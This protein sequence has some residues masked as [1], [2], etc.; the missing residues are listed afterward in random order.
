[1]KVATGLVAV[2]ALLLA[3]C[4]TDGVS[5]ASGT[6]RLRFGGCPHE[7]MTAADAMVPEERL[8]QLTFS[9]ATL[10]VPLDHT[11]LDGESIPIAVVRVRHRQQSRRIGSLVMN[12]GGPGESGLDAISYWASWLSDDVLRRFDVVTFDPRGTGASDPVTCGSIAADHEPTLF[13]DLL[14]PAGY[15]AASDIARQQTDACLR[16]LGGRAPFFNTQETARDMDLLRQALGDRKLS[17]VGFSY[18]AKLGGEYAR[19]FPRTVRALVLDGPS[20]PVTDPI[21][22][23]EAQV[24]GFEHAFGQWVTDCPARPSCQPLG[25]P[26]AYVATLVARANAAPINSARPGDDLPATGSDVLL[27]VEAFLYD[28]VTWPFLDAALTEAADG[29]AGSVFEAIDHHFGR[30]RRSHPDDPDPADAGLVINCNDQAAG[31]SDREIQEAATRVTAANPIFGGLGSWG[32]LGCRFWRADRHVLALPQAPATAPVLVV[33]TVHDPATPYAGA[34]SF[35]E[36]MGN[37]TLLSWEGDGHTAYGR[38]SCVN[39]LVDAYLTTLAV[40]AA[41]TRCPP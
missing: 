30:D 8:E 38:S 31:P 39:E 2:A 15:A 21:A 27:A 12:P 1:M 10:Q 9:C 23:T 13:P 41:G 22:T 5:Q 37:A 32:L 7:L 4:S 35:T 33:G 18:G 36:T 11:H 6:P 19:R 25:D 17:Y 28:D 40:P 14:S 16:R 26:R 29:D 34:V 24:A 3:G 20:D